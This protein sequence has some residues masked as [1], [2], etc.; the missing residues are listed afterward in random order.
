ML[1]FSR[2]DRE[3]NPDQV[4]ATP[5]SDGAYWASYDLTETGW[6][7]IEVA[8]D[9]TAS[10]SFYLRLDNPSQGPLTFAP[11]DYPSDPAAEQVF[12]DAL[13]RYQ[14]LKSLKWREELTS[15]LLAPTGIGAWVVTDAEGEAPDRIHYHVVSRGSSDYQLYRVGDNSCAQDKGGSWR[16]SRGE[17]SESFDLD[18]MNPPTA[19]DF[20]RR[21]LVDGE[22]TQVV[23]FYNPSQPAWYTWW[24]GVDTGQLRRRAMVAAGHFMLTRFYDQDLPTG[25]AIPSDAP[26]SQSR[27]P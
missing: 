20:G 1:R 10:A 22:M 5:S 27:A 13:S 23:L 26:T 14:N 17:G 8:L 21:E 16:C 18:Y 15:G 19:C 12:R 6:W 7:A 3:E 25:I 9:G 2:L 4:A 24:V 11:P